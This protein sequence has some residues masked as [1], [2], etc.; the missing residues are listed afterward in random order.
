VSIEDAQNAIKDLYKRHKEEEIER[1]AI[2]G[3]AYDE[4]ADPWKGILNY[5]LC[6]Y[7]ENGV[8]LDEAIARKQKR[9]E[10]W[11][12][13][14]GDSSWPN[15]EPPQENFYTVKHP[16]TGINHPCPA[17]GWRWP[18]ETETDAMSFVKMNADHRIYFG[19][20]SP[21]RHNKETGLPEYKVP[22]V[23]RFLHEA[24]TDVSK[25]SFVDTTDGTKELN[26]VMG[27][28]A[29]F[30][31][32]KPTSLM[33]RFALQT[34]RNND[35]VLDY[36]C[37][38]G[39]TIH[40]VQTIP[41]EFGARKFLG[42]EVGDNFENLVVKRAKK[43][44]YAHDWNDG[45]VQSVNHTGIFFRYHRLEQ[46]EDSLENIHTKTLSDLPFDAPTSLRYELDKAA[47]TLTEGIIKSPFGF[48][49]KALTDGVNSQATEVDLVES[50]IYL[51]GLHVDK[52]YKDGNGIVITGNQNLTDIRITVAFR[53][54]ET[55]GMDWVKSV[56]EKNPCDAFYANQLGDILIDFGNT[57]PNGIEAVFK[58]N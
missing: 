19:D 35:Y 39:S 29:S 37:G 58:G 33:R 15:D 47:V 45:I 9:G 2:D 26:H 32:P 3:I 50:I 5:K 49:I 42:V 44:A 41:Y 7:R 21:V 16:I 55:Q 48:T 20:G 12:F 11:V 13:R 40:A 28:R 56:L 4:K 6:E 38:S 17:N 51:L 53:D 1:L 10:L 27:E 54:V 30:K 36:F 34:T 52:L 24:E 23:K 25:S 46:Y 22:Q 18:Y 14:E 57:N 31:N 8:Y 43:L